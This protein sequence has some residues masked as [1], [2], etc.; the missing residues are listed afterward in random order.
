MYKLKRNIKLLSPLHHKI[1]TDYP[2]NCKPR[3]HHSSLLFRELTLKLDSYRNNYVD[4]LNRCLKY[5][6]NI[7]KFKEKKDETR[8]DAPVWNNGFLPGLDIITLY[9][10]ISELKPN[11]YLEIGSGNSTK[12]VKRAIQDFSL[13]TKIIS[14]DPKPRA[15]IDDLSDEIIRKPL[16]NIENIS[17]IFSQL[18]AND[19]LFIDNSH[20]LFPNSDVFVCMYEILPFLNAGVWIQIHDIYLPYDYPE[21]MTQRYYNEQYSLIPFILYATHDFEIM[22]PNYYIF[23]NKE[24]HTLL[25][26]YWESSELKNVENHGGSFWMRKK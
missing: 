8:K 13:T 20:Y 24:L 4:W 7:L 12:V 11:I 17:V 9:S 21:I 22:L 25:A 5:T 10:V 6:D 2:V 19:V 18:S 14:I 16:E 1:I 23:K 15:E 26:K 3:I